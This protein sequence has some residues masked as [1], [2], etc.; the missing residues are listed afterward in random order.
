MPS[1]P[2]VPPANRRP[3]RSS[4]RGFANLLDWYATELALG[5]D[6]R[7]LVIS[8]PSFDLTQKNLFAPLLT[9]GT[10]ILDDCQT[11]DITRILG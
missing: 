11:Y 7:T 9:G 3:L 10:L 6:D 5:P 2:R 4:T 1:S 8:S